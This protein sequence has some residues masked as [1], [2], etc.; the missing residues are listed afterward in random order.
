MTKT[1][2]LILTGALLVSLGVAHATELSIDGQWNGVVFGPEGDVE[3]SVVFATVE[4]ELTGTVDAPMSGVAGMVLEGV[5][6]EGNLVK[7]SVPLPDAQADCSGEIQ[8]D[9]KTIKGTVEQMG[10]IADFE[11]TRAEE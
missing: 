9:G 6:L 7:W 10:V 4:G 1:L 8:E 3:F 11:L 2:S 5:S